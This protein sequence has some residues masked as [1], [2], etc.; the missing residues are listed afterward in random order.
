M[1]G[2]GQLRV[3]VGRCCALPGVRCVGAWPPAPCPRCH[4]VPGTG[5][6]AQ[7]PGGLRW[8]E[9]GNR[10]GLVRVGDCPWGGTGTSRGLPPG[11]RPKTV[12]V[13]SQ[14]PG[15]WSLGQSRSRSRSPLS[16]GTQWWGHPAQSRYSCRVPLLICRVS[17][18]SQ[19]PGVGVPGQSR[20]RSP[21][22]PGTPGWVS[23]P[24]PS[25]PGAGLCPR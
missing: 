16:P 21:P 25:P 12:P 19:R 18:R 24:G 10:A 13:R 11:P 9:S 7:G 6:A 3:S 5:A 23:R 20:P 8:R 17:P 4:P 1:P 2:Q 15:V 14:N 22:S